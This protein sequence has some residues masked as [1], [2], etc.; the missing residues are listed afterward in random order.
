LPEIGLIPYGQVSQRVSR[1]H[2]KITW[3]NG[4]PFVEDIGSGF[5]TRLYGAVLP[6]G[7]TRPLLPGDHIWLAGCVLAYDIEVPDETQKLTRNRT[8]HVHHSQT[9]QLRQVQLPAAQAV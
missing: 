3:Q 6:L 4:K 8:G 2:A 5:G 1:R 9:T 7:E